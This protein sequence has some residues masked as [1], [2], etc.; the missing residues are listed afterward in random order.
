MTKP[1][2]PL[3][4]KTN[5]MDKILPYGVASVSTSTADPE[6]SKLDDLLCSQDFIKRGKEM[7]WKVKERMRESDL[8]EENN[9]ASNHVNSTSSSPTVLVASNSSSMRSYTYFGSQHGDG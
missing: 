6:W 4:T 5:S 8:K 7:K 2:Q 9:L 3:R 1:P